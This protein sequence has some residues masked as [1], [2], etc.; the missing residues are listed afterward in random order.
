MQDNNLYLIGTKLEERKHEL[1]KQVKSGEENGEAI[2]IYEELYQ[3]FADGLK[4]GKE[5]TYS[6][7][8]DW[9][10]RVGNLSI[11]YGG[12]LDEAL[13]ETSVFRDLL[14][15]A[16]ERI[17]KE[18]EHS[19]DTVFEV[20]RIIDP[21]LDEAIYMFSKEYISSYKEK[22]ENAQEEFLKLSAPVVPIY[23]GVAVLPIIGSIDEQRAYYLMDTS[24][25]EATK[26]QLNYLL[27]DLSG[28]AVVDTMVAN[29]IYSIIHSLELV[30][31]KAILAG[32]RPEVAQTMVSLGINF[33]EIQTY[34]SL[35]QALSSHVFE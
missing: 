29:S 25:K 4:N 26:R 11:D 16:V 9:G 17:M 1:A 22:L 27:I 24:L 3:L 5:N 33:S 31:V 12:K 2:K 14:W 10:T 7:I 23:E 8:S 13:K 21:L 35:Q 34:N 30:G 32:I 20:A 28:V 15:A 19:L 6:K 18:E